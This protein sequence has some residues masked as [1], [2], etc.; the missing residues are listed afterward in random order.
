MM[1][2]GIGKE[3]SIVLYLVEIDVHVV[4]QTVY[5]ILM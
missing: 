4:H 5:G 2:M 3:K 1:K